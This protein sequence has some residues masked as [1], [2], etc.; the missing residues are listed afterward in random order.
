MKDSWPDT[1]DTTKLVDEVNLQLKTVADCKMSEVF[2]VLA[3]SLAVLEKISGGMPDGGSWKE[4]CEDF[5]KGEN[6]NWK[7]TVTRAK[8]TVMHQNPMEIVD[9]V[10]KTKQALGK[11]QHYKKHY[12][13]RA[14]T[15]DEMKTVT[16]ADK[17]IKRGR[18]P[19]QTRNYARKLIRS[20][21][22]LLS[23][24]ITDN[25]ID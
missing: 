6:A 3:D 15:E 7:Q 9:G 16:E 17:H 8:E 12:S 23:R 19:C 5:K 24:T 20:T 22:G 18:S 2:K 11:C 21:V 10:H 1:W 25:N 14:F 13:Y 4:S